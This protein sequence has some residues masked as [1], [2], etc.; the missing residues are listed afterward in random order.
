MLRKKGIN[1][2]VNSYL[3]LKVFFTYKQR[4]ILTF[5]FWTP[6]RVIINRLL[7]NK[8]VK[9]KDYNDEYR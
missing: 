8:F 3:P 7:K 4:D 6:K 9:P 5:S 1:E 2:S